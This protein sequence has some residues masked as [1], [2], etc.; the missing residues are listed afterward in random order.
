MDC[1]LFYMEYGKVRRKRIVCFNMVTSSR[2]REQDT[3][4]RLQLAFAFWLENMKKF[5]FKNKEIWYESFINEMSIHLKMSWN[6]SS[7][8]LTLLRRNTV[9]HFAR[10]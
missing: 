4:Q 10:S 7:V 5:T 3:H 6:R 1:G 9:T 8:N 2:V